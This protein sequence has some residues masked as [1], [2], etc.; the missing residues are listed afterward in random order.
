MKIGLNRKSKNFNC[1]HSVQ[2]LSICL[3]GLKWFRRE[4]MNVRLGYSIKPCFHY[5]TVTKGEP[6]FNP[7]R[8]NPRRIL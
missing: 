7:N 2:L 3:F 8:A 1:K 5:K 6:E 4:I